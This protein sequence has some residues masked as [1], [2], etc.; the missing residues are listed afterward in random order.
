MRL[1]ED[2]LSERLL[3]AGGA[4]LGDHPEEEAKPPPQRVVVPNRRQDPPRHQPLSY[5]LCS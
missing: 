2:R 4:D 3:A 5:S 1:K